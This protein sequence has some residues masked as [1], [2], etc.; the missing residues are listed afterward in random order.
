MTDSINTL[1]ETREPMS[2]EE[3][4]MMREIFQ[5]GQSSVSNNNYSLLVYGTLFFVMSLPI[6]DKIIK[7]FVNTTDL[8]LIALK[9]VLFVMIIF[10]ANLLGLGSP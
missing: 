3:T 10:V 6:T 4:N 9:S 8:I 7:G 5:A 2:M 1:P